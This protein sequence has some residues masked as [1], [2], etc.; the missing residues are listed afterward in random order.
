[1]WVL[2]R[3]LFEH[4]FWPFAFLLRLLKADFRV[5]RLLN[6]FWEGLLKNFAFVEPFLKQRGALHHRDSTC[7]V[8][9]ECFYLLDECWIGPFCVEWMLDEPKILADFEISRWMSVGWALDTRWM[10][11]IFRTEMS[12]LPIA[13][14]TTIIQ[15]V[16]EIL[17]PCLSRRTWWANKNDR[18]DC[19]LVRTAAL[20]VWF[21]F[22]R[23]RLHLC[24][25]V[26]LIG[27]VLF[28]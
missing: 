15:G 6:R 22:S 17:F 12:P 16:L 27:S 5:L 2:F 19:V 10:G 3:A 9:D 24:G 7:P 4:R 1:M 28:R 21:S 20:I 23:V 18:S 26:P 11:A 8:L 13:G 14:K 25:I